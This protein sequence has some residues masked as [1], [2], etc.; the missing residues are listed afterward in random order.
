VNRAKSGVAHA[1]Q[2]GLLGVGFFAGKGEVKV[3]LD[4]KAKGRLKARLRRLTSRRWRVAMAVRLAALNRFIT[5][6]A[7]YFAL[8]GTPSV[9]AEFDEWLLRR[10]RQVR[11]KE[12]KRFA[13]AT[14]PPSASP[15]GRLASGR[16]AGRGTGG[17][18]GPHRS[19]GPCPFGTGSI[20]ASC[21]SVIASV[22]FGSTG[23]PPDADPHVR[24]CGR[25]R[26]NLGPYPI[27]R[28]C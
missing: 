3:R 10:L 4:R 5:G 20:S 16:P 22:V 2:R 25:G 1:T 21:R 28:R 26:A 23:E 7:A 27:V 18:R 8:A 9:F 14:S 11:W 24:W 6:W 12:W 15:T 13:A 17:S 19:S